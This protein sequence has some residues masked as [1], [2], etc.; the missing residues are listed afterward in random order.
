MF[1]SGFICLLDQLGQPTSITNSINVLF[2][3][4]GKVLYYVETRDI[5]A[6]F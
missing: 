3:L 2:V 4:F 5:G 1:T 6:E